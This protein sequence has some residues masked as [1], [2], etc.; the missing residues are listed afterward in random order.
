[1]TNNNEDLDCLKTVQRTNLKARQIYRK[2]NIYYLL[3][4]TRACA[5]HWVR[6]VLFWK[7]W[8]ALFSC[9]TPFSDLPVCL[10]ADIIL[11]CIQTEYG[12]LQSTV[13]KI[14]IKKLNLC[15]LLLKTNVKF[16]TFEYVKNIKGKQ[17]NICNA[18]INVNQM[19]FMI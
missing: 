6:N 1:M 4:R 2:T 7:I 3:L 8:F 11:S 19:F 12:D 17:E 16:R 14:W 18:V 15:N 5:Y 9:N 13:L 10:I